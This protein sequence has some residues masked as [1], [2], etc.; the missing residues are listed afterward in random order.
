MRF[1]RRVLR[2]RIRVAGSGSDGDDRLLLTRQVV[3][4]PVAALE[5]AQVLLRQRVPH[6]GP[7][8]SLLL[9]EL[10]VRVVLRFFLHQPL[11]HK[12]NHTGRPASPG[13][14][15]W[16]APY[17]GLRE[18]ATFIRILNRWVQAVM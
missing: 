6:S 14:A 2:V 1:A 12:T 15:R 9:D 10:V 17:F 7:D 18:P 5:R 4:H 8:R 16:D 3:E 11:R 13:E